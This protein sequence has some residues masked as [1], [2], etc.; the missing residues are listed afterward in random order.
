MNH[1]LEVAT[2]LDMMFDLNV[3]VQGLLECNRAQTE[4]IKSHYAHMMRTFFNNSRTVYAST[5]SATQGRNYQHDQRLVSLAE[6]MMGRIKEMGQDKWGLCCW[7]K[8]SR[9]VMKE[10]LHF[11]D[12]RCARTC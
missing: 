4:E 6:K 5:S 11:R 9:R 10:D 8:N 1:G 3:N 7:A 12:T 2:E